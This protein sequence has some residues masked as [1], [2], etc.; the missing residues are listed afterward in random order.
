MKFSGEQIVQLSAKLDATHVKQREQAGRM[1]SYIEGWHAISE[2]NRIFGFDGW[3]RE[4]VD[5]RVVSEKPRK[6]GRAPN[7]RD[8][9]GVTYI[10]RVRVTVGS[11]AREGVGAGHGIDVDL[12]QAHESAIKEAETD[13]M[14][15]CLMTFGNPFGLALYDKTQE[16]VA[17]EPEKPAEPPKENRA[18]AWIAK[19]KDHV[20]KMTVRAQLVNWQNTDNYKNAIAAIKE[21]CPEKHTDFL[22]WLDAAF[23]KLA[24]GKETA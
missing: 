15:R 5:I 7:T 6:I 3:T 24:P 19:A 16:G 23:N 13:A 10:A 2:A 1:L 4:T 8:G 14:K 9:W 17:K 20:G 18:D 11:V 22:A 21:E 12:G